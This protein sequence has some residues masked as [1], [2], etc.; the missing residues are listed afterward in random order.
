MT[1]EEGNIKRQ[2]EEIH[3][4]LIGTFEKPGVMRLVEKM[5][6]DLYSPNDPP[7]GLMHRVRSL[8]NDKRWVLGFAAAIAAG[9]GAIVAWI[10]G[11][12]TKP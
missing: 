3:D 10:K 6:Q 8:E 12:I 11:L 2:L 1:D 5:G 9:T 4:A 7:E